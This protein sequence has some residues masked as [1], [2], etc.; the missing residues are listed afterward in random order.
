MHHLPSRK[1]LTCEYH[2]P[3]TP[4]QLLAALDGVGL[5]LPAATAASA[6]ADVVRVEAPGF[7]ITLRLRVVAGGTGIV[8][9]FK[10]CAKWAWEKLVN[11][12]HARLP[13][14][15]AKS[16]ASAGPTKSAARPPRLSVIEAVRLFRAEADNSQYVVFADKALRQA[17]DCVFWNGDAVLECLRRLVFASRRLRDGDHQGDSLRNFFVNVIGLRGYRPRISYSQL[18]MYREDYVA[19]H[20]DQEF[21]GHM[22]VTIGGA[23]SDSGCMSIHWSYCAKRRQIVIVRCGRHGRTYRS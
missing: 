23:N 19:V 1:N 12:I 6:A 22:H 9:K 5:V 4:S 10:A 16:V 18:N 3:A 2:T 15:C 20:E 17:E 7:L 21:L 14:R 11:F 8:M 13:V